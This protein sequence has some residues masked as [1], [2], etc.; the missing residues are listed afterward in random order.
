MISPVPP[1][2][3]HADAV[4]IC[5][6]IDWRT[7]RTCPVPLHSVHCTACVPALAPVDEHL[8]Q[9]TSVLSVTDTS[10]PNTAV[11]NG[12]STIASRSAPRGG[13]EGERPPPKGL[14]PKNASNRSDKP[15]L[16]GSP[17]APAA[18]RKP[19]MP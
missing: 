10:P 17:P 18:R 1:Q 6:R 19:S 2:R 9:P 3:L 7:R 8:S 13:P 12:T 5:P 16:N 15:P 4:T 14:P 11:S